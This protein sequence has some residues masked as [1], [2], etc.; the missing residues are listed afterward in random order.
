MCLMVVIK[1]EA[2]SR[3]ELLPSDLQTD[4]LPAYSD[5]I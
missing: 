5:A 2:S 4:V 3:I 1:L